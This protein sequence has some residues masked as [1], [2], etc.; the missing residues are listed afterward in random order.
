MSVVNILMVVDTAKLVHDK[1]SLIPNSSFASPI[2]L[3][4]GAS[5]IYM[6]ADYRFVVGSNA[7]SELKIQLHSEDIIRWRVDAIDKGQSLSPLFVEFETNYDTGINPADFLSPFP[8]QFVKSHINVYEP[9]SVTDLDGPSSKV[10]FP[11]YYFETTAI[12][13]PTGDT[14][15]TYQWKF[16][17]IDQDGVVQGYFQWD[18]FIVILQ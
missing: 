12:S 17:L 13:A 18:P 14:T 10:T 9:N 15:V 1:A 5:Y 11:D 3:G 8:P 7:I 16:K 4:N 6:V 2:G